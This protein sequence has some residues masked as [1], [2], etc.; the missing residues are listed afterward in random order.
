MLRHQGAVSRGLL[1]MHRHSVLWAYMPQWS[2]IVGQMQF[3]LFHAYTVD[4]HTVRVMLKLES[5]AK[6]ETRSRHPLC[7]ELWPRLTHPELIL[8]AAL[9]HDI[10]K[11]RGGDH[12]IL[13]AQDVLKF[14]ELHGLNSRETQLVAWLVRHHLLMSVTAQRRDIQDPE[15]I[16]QFAEEVQTE[17]RLRYLVCLTVADICATNETLWNSW[18]QSLL[19]EL[20]FATEKQLRRGMQSTPDMRERVR[21]HQLQALA[22]LRMDNINEEALHQIWNRCRANYFVRHTPTQLAWH[23]RNLLRHDLNKPM[24]LLSSQATRGG[25]EI[26]SGARI[27]LTCSPRCVANLTVATSASTTRRSSPPATVWRWIPLSSLSPTAAPFPP[28]ATRRSARGWSRPSLSAA[29]SLRPRVVRRQSYAI[30]R[31][32]RGEFPADPYRPKIV[33]GADSARPAR[34]AR[35][36]RAGVRRPRDI[37]SRGAN[38]DNW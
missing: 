30:F 24:I 3:D 31:G 5:F 6:E 23:A 4:E 17:N 15:V 12:S 8:I 10:A 25:T 16:K 35:P 32:H 26:L 13:G 29:G 20:Y 34:A 2:H 36:R 14:A 38:Y 37:A 21:H 27:V 11:G 1:P 28:T 22:L 33:S 18:K 9:F 7:V 19:R